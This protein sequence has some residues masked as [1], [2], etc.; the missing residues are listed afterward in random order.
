MASLGAREMGL[1]VF[2]QNFKGVVCVT[3]ILTYVC[4]CVCS[5]ARAVHGQLCPSFL[6]PQEK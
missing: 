3:L 6:K 5:S 1:H 2:F 4:V